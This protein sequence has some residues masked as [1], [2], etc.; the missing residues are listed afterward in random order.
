MS[1]MLRV[2]G[3][4]PLLLLVVFSACA[5]PPMRPGEARIPEGAWVSH[6]AVWIGESDHDTIGTVSLYQSRE[7]PVIVF[8]P[9][10]RVSAA[11]DAVVALGTDGYRADT[12]LGA[13]LRP[14]GQQAYA[15]PPGIDIRLFNEVWLWSPTADEPV[16]L[17]R[18]T[19]I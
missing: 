2:R 4:L 9:N 16:G 12:V 5:G 6:R 19:P 8:E 18:L 15:L 7:Y 11:P 13:L 1:G 17:A 14:I 3:L 10:F